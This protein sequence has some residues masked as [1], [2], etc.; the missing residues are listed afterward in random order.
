MRTATKPQVNIDGTPALL[1]QMPAV[2]TEQQV[3]TAQEVDK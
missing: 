1:S 2:T 3:T